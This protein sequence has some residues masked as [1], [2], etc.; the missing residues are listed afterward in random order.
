M[1]QADGCLDG[2]CGGSHS[3]HHPVKLPLTFLYHSWGEKPRACWGADIRSD[4]QLSASAGV[5]IPFLQCSNLTLLI[6]TLQITN[7]T[8]SLGM[9]PCVSGFPSLAAHIMR[10]YT[11]ATFSP[12]QQQEAHTS[13]KQDKHPC[14]SSVSF[15]YN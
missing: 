14:L 11:L 9:T 4:L 3:N 2:R 13:S 12:N 6:Y 7:K 1:S 5:S 15:E 10:G 8:Q